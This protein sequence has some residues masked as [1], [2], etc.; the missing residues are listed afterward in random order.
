MILFWVVFAGGFGYYTQ[1][2][3]K[4]AIF[5]AFL[6]CFGTE[7]FAQESNR[8]GWHLSGEAAFHAFSLGLLEDDNSPMGYGGGANIGGGYR[9][10]G[11]WAIRGYLHTAAVQI[12]QRSPFFP[13]QSPDY[14]IGVSVEPILHFIKRPAKIDPYLSLTDLEFLHLVRNNSPAL[15]VGLPGLGLQVRLNDKL[16]MYVAGRVKLGS[17][18]RGG[19]NVNFVVFDAELVTGLNRRF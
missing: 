7:L 13:R 16:S 5:S 11:R 17:T 4:R 14:F 2:M 9:G 12:T 6:I 19:N 1:P 8:Q 15:L 18:L 10:K 3:A